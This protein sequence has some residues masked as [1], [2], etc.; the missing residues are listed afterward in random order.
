V[1]EKYDTSSIIITHDIEC[2][3]L[4]ANRIIVMKDGACAAEG[5][6]AQLANSPDAWIRSFFE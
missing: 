6:Y 1:Q 4:T 3:K 2:A 5:S